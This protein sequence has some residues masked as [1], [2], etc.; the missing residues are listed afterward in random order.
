MILYMNGCCIT[1]PDTIDATCPNCNHVREYET[2]EKRLCNSKNGVI[3]IK[4][5]SCKSMLGVSSDY[6][7]N[8]VTW[9]KKSENDT[10]TN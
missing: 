6:K 7:G 2:F 8:T 5:Q 3:Y 1:I 10:P 4:C 9:L